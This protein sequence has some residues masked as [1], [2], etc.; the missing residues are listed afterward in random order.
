MLSASST[1]PGPALPMLA[2]SKKLGIRLGVLQRE[3]AQ[4][5]V[6]HDA[7]TGRQ[8]RLHDLTRSHD[9]VDAPPVGQ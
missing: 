5:P 7:R 1:L 8:R 2:W 4:R 9:V 3:V 6:S